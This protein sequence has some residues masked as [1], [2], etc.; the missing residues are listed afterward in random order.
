MSKQAFDFNAHLIS[1]KKEHYIPNSNIFVS[2]LLP[3]AIPKAYT[4]RVPKELV[5]SV[6]FGVRVE[7]QF[8]RNKMYSAV[9]I[10]IHQADPNQY[11]AKEIVSVI[12]KEAII[13]KTQ[14]KF[15][16][17]MSNY[18]CCTIGE[19]MNA[20]LPGGLR[21]DSETTLTIHPLFDG[22]ADM[23][24]D[25]EYLIFEA[26]TIQP[27]LSIEQVYQVLQIKTIRPIIY[28]LIE[29]RVVMIKEEL[30][31]KYKVRTV[32]AVRLQEP[33]RSDEAKLSEAFGMVEK[34]SSRQLEALMA[35]IQ[36]SRNQELV[37]AQE[38]YDKALVELSVLRALEKKGIFEVYRKDI[39]RLGIYDEDTQQS[40]ALSA[41]QQKAISEIKLSF[42]EKNVVLLHG[43]TG[44]GKTRVYAELIREAIDRGEQVLYLLPEIALTTQI[45]SRL[46][47]V[48]GDDI[49]VYHS[50]C[51][52]AERVEL[53]KKALEGKPIILSA[54]SGLFL[55]FS[56]LGLIVVDEEHDGS[57]KQSEPAP[58]YN[59]RDSA[60]LLAMFHSAKVLLGTA[61]PSVESYYN[62]RSG[63]YGLVRM[64]ERFGGLQLPEIIFANTLKDPK[65][66]AKIDFTTTLIEALRAGYAQKEQ[67]IVF[68][69]K[70]GYAPYL[71]CQDCAWKADCVNCDVSLTYHKGAE[72][73]RCHYCGH[74]EQIPR[75]CP[76]CGSGKLSIKGMG[77]EKVEDELKIFLPDA[78]IGR[79]DTD[80]IKT[81][82]AHSRIINDFEEK[83]LDILV[84]TQMVTKGLDFDN[85]SL[86]GVVN[87]DSLLYFP[88]F[89]ASERAFQLLMQ[90]AGRAGRKNKRGRV[91]VQTSNPLH[92]VLKD[93]EKGDYLSFFN[94]EIQERRD[95][96][97]PPFVLLIQ[98]QIRHKKPEVV[99][100]ASR[101][102]ADLLKKQLGKRVVG[103]ALPSVAR[104]RN[105]Y[106]MDIMIK[107]EKDRQM[108]DIAKNLLI[109]SIIDLKKHPGLSTVDVVI[110]VDPA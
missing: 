88:E 91:I 74:F 69:N 110:N 55:P 30:K 6:S 19:V 47:Q 65:S 106:L 83:R 1:L 70:R 2:V 22:N 64:A 78:Q 51:G 97:Y 46:Q 86:V 26:L 84:G 16:Q 21:L 98:V 67:S 20:A 4:Y 54:R 109:N 68:Q 41:Q 62:A 28:S 56:K 80:A 59:A 5:D 40:P 29:K 39:S 60:I 48:F 25:R 87:A 94:R 63:K 103:P 32:T 107:I 36:L 31:T 81:R 18:Y 77:T 33:F 89:R 82:N 100:D 17:W 57:F 9:V 23:L 45:T 42:I 108:I 37:L 52:D 58:R 105:Y 10:D 3:L 71:Q 7:V 13:T 27:E 50:K 90:V 73:L 79:M 101:I 75:V 66:K 93:V 72:R 38:I 11:D 12:D 96:M 102:Y 43:V 61:T 92:P 85:V 95:F 104:V 24:S 8:G 44:S 34:K 76:A 49:I 14:L 53:W 15:W 35:Y 99:N